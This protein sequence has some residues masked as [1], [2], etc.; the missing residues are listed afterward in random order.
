MPLLLACLIPLAAACSGGDDDFD[1]EL[2]GIYAIASW[3]HNPDGCDAE[4]PADEMAADYSHLFIRHEEFLG[5]DFVQASICYNLEECRLNARNEETLFLPGYSFDG[6]DDQAGWSG[7][8]Y[9][10]LEE[11]AACS[12]QVLGNTLTGEP[13]SSIRIEQTVK[14]VDGVPL[15]SNHGCDEEEASQ[16]AGALPCAELR[17]LTGSWVEAF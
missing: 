8:E 11:G 1:T 4:G 16:Q 14:D 5:I 3:T 6:G 17:V 12:G 9:L 13:A 10:L 7:T 2:A 15:D